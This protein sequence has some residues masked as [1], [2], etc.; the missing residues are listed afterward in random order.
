MCKVDWNCVECL[1]S[2]INSLLLNMCPKRMDDFDAV[3]FSECPEE[4]MVLFMLGVQSLPYR[5]LRTRRALTLFSNVLLRT[6]RVLTLFSNVLLRTRRVLT[7]FSNVLLR[8]RRVL[9]L[10][11]NVLLRTRRVLTHFSN[12]LLRTRRALTHFSNVSVEN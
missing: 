4:L 5:R 6:R 9:T 3:D 2:E 12:V 7:L 1:H 8:T 11:S 10:F